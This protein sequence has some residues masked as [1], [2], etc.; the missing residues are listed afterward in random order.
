MPQDKLEVVKRAVDANN[1]R[2]V[3]GLFA[4]LVTPDFLWE[5]ALAGGLDGGSYEDAKAS[6][7]LPPTRANTGRSSKTPLRNSAIWAIRCLCWVGSQGRG[8]GSGVPVDQPY[9]GI[10]DFRGNRIWRYRAY[11]D[12]A[13]GGLGRHCQPWAWSTILINVLEL[14]IPRL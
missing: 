1:R 7:D 13:E 11:F 12:R 9:T 14:R 2:D 10:L 5:S 4:E 6:N 8:K 3:D